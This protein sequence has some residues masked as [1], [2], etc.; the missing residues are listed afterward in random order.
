[1]ST[2]MKYIIE[3]R[4]KT[5]GKADIAW[6]ELAVQAVVEGKEVAQ[7]EVDKEGRY[8][9]TFEHGERPPATELRVVPARLLR[10]G[11]RP[12]ALRRMLS[13][14]RYVLKRQSDPIYHASWDIEIPRDYHSIVRRVTETYHMYG[15]VY[16]AVYDDWGRLESV[17]PLPAAKIEFYEHSFR[18]QMTDTYMGYAYT[19]PEGS[20]EFD[21]DFSYF[22]LG[23]W[24][25][26]SDKTPDMF[27]RIYQFVGGIWTQV[28]MGPVDW[29]IELDFHRDYF[30]PVEDTFPVLDAGVKP[31][32]GFR[33]V[34]VGLL[35]I[36]ETRIVHGYATSQDGDPIKLSEQ[37]FCEKLRVFG[38]FAEA[39]PVA[40]YK[41]Q[42]A[43]ADEDGPTTGAAWEDVADALTNQ[44][45]NDAEQRWDPVPLGPDPDTGRYRN[46]DSEPEADWHEHALKFTWNSAN[47]PNGYY[48]LQIIGY[49]EAGAEVGT[50]QMPVVR[51]DNT[52]PEARIDAPGVGDCGY[53][54][55]PDGRQIEF[56]V[57]AH[58]PSGHILKYQISW[59]RGKLPVGPVFTHV[60][61]RDLPTDHWEGVVDAD[62]SLRMAELPPGLAD[63]DVL[64]YNFELQVQ[65]SPTNCYSPELISQHVKK[66]VNLA[67]TE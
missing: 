41:V 62:V 57:T 46:I 1:M 14:A 23:M 32:E 30:I 60:V 4:L 55:L 29:N 12:F 61:A 67:I 40:T 13:A 63:C 22:A 17:D 16:A 15:E 6:T 47:K 9:L 50:F 27:V 59:T 43:D 64:A 5:T 31:D 36:D 39:P 44:K 33:Y 58:D 53:L 52:P 11:A 48:A 19:G 45:W 42:V 28:Y 51:V 10:R 54:E 20:Y 25:L 66:E 56:R 37:P 49:D 21:F 65:G 26:S 35:P 7:A 3:G 2:R 8:K 34:S 18:P 24:L 38:L